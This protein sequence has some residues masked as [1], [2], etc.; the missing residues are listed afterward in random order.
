MKAKLMVNDIELE[1]DISEEELKKLQ[2]ED[3]KKK[4]G[5]ERVGFGYTYSFV[6]NYGEVITLN[7]QDN[8]D[9]SRYEEANYYSDYTIAENN[10]RADRLMR[11]LRRFAVESRSVGIDWNK[12]DMAKFAIYYNRATKKLE[13]VNACNVREF[14]SIYFD[15]ALHAHQAIEAFHDELIWY[16][17]EYKDSL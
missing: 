16:F 13:P 7:H 9:N 15:L 12:K 14:G 1:V 5:Y 6:N 10:A 8:D 11:Q 2:K 17:T 3:K 4:I